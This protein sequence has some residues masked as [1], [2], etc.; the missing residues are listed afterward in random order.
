MTRPLP[1]LFDGINDVDLV[2]GLRVC[3]ERTVQA[4]E[5]VLRAG[6][7][8]RGLLCVLEGEYDVR[9]GGSTV[10]QVTAGDLVGEMALFEETERTADV[11]ATTAGKI[12]VLPRTGYERLRDVMHPMA[13]AV[14]R[15]AIQLQ[16]DRLRAVSDRIVS[17]AEDQ[18]AP[19]SRPSERF[20]VA[21]KSLFGLGGVSVAKQIDAIA[22]LAR[23]SIFADA[24]N[25]AL[26]AVARHFRPAAYDAGHLLCVEGEKG[27]TMYILARGEVDV[28]VATAENQVKELAT[29]EPGAVFGMLSLAQ[30]RP[31][32]ATCVARTPVV[33]LVL[34]LGGWNDLVDEPG[35]AGSTF[36]RALLRSL[37]DQL[38][39]ANRRLARYEARARADQ[40]EIGLAR[41]GV[42]TYPES[43]PS[44]TPAPDRDRR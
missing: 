25:E 5:V 40:K 35:L 2:T 9:A 38:G 43:L 39:Y 24:A 3:E 1:A 42:D 32:M 17:L 30:D 8:A 18:P 19:F 36:R 34:D 10:G 20:F 41:A 14:E 29:L 26:I 27:Q 28:V 22:A 11:V 44:E 13:V 31:R 21:L 15:H 12:L 4:G 33:T 6:E 16:I 7:P 23:A 37:N